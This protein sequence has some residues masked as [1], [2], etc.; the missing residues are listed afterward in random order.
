MHKHAFSHICGYT[1]AELRILS[2]DEMYSNYEKQIGA[3]PVNDP[4]TGKISEID[5]WLKQNN[6]NYKNIEYSQW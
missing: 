3:S 1:S 2:K 6:N 4:L 5:I